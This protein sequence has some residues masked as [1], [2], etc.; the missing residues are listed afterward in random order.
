MKIFEIEKLYH[1]S[2]VKF[3]EIDLRHGKSFKDFGKG[4][5]LTTNRKQA[6]RWA[7]KKGEKNRRAY[8][9]EYDVK[10]I[11]NDSLHI[12]E[13]LSYDKK[14]LDFITKC[15]S[16]GMETDY[17]LIYDRM[18]DNQ[19]NEIAQTIRGYV[20]NTVTVE[21]AIQTIRWNKEADQYCFKT[22]KALKLLCNQRITVESMDKNG[23][24]IVE[25]M[26]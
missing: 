12:L 22:E 20:E 2:N 17:D 8:I 6:Q 7:Q 10:A 13:L 14:W 23:K 1:G 15:R 25:E 5:Y 9:Y 21:K 24:W 4:F 26:K 18:A 19:Y 3:D 16:E 11:T